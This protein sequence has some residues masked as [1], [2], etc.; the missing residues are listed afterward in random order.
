MLRRHR[1]LLR[2]SQRN[3][4]TVKRTGLSKVPKFIEQTVAPP[5]IEEDVQKG[6]LACAKPGSAR[7]QA[8]W[9]AERTREYVSTTN[10]RERR[11]RPFSTSE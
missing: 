9:R 5:Y 11:W 3:Q 2:R 10:G 4:Q 7:P 1:G 8:S 6:S